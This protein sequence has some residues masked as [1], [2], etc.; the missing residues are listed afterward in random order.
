V[1]TTIPASQSAPDDAARGVRLLAALPELGRGVPEEDRPLAWRALVAPVAEVPAG[2]LEVEAVRAQAGTSRF[3]IVLDGIVL[4]TTLLDD[5]AVTEIA[6]EADI[7]DLGAEGDPSAVAT[8]TRHVVHRRATIA[9]IGERFR[10]AARRWPGLHDALYDQLARQS[11]RASTH[12]A[13]LQQPRVDDRITA[14]FTDL[15]DRLGRVT[16]TASCST[17]RSPMS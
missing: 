7:L 17:C 10:L 1:A 15:S 6:G 5:R 14:V 8:V 12:L 13:I 2:P 4:K 3:A 9:F 11:R 16:P